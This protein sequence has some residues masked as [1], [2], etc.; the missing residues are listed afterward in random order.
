MNCYQADFRAKF[1]GV[2]REK[3]SADAEF[4]PRRPPR[5]SLKVAAEPMYP[6]ETTGGEIYERGT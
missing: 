6:R 1:E 3:M 4:G 5:N 2:T